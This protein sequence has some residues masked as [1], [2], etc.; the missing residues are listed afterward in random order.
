MTGLKSSN[1]PCSEPKLTATNRGQPSIASEKLIRALLQ[2][3]YSIR[4]ERTLMEQ[5]SYK[6][7]FRRFVGLAMDDAAWDH[8][9]FSKNRDRLLVQ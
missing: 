5:I 1:S 8:S 3:L 9:T 6:M 4:C 2:A 7:L